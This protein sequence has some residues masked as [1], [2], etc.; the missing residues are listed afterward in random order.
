M[1]GKKAG[2]VTNSW[3]T[4][5][6]AVEVHLSPFTALVVNTRYPDSCQYFYQNPF[7][8]GTMQTQSIYP[9]EGSFSYKGK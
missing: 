3:T 9:Q 8:P 2:S 5:D 6:T 1:V 7:M 4:G